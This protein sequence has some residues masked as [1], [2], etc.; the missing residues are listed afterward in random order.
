MAELVLDTHAFVW[1]L[2]ASPRLSA[3]ARSRIDEAFSAGHPVYV[4]AISLVELLY[5]VEKGRIAKDLYDRLDSHIQREDTGLLVAPV[6]R[7][8]VS[9]MPEIPRDAVPDLPDRVIA[10]TALALGAPL[11]TRDRKIRVSGIETIW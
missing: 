4:S 7:R 10:A 3:G 1:F 6:D 5:L 9:R 2:C 8:I 11:V